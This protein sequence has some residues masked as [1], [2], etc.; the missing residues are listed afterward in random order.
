MCRPLA[1]V[2][3][4]R[5]AKNKRRRNAVSRK[6]VKP[7]Q[8][9][10]ERSS[11]PSVAPL[12]F[13]F[14]TAATRI[15]ASEP[16]FAVGEPLPKRRRVMSSVSVAIADD[17]VMV[18][19]EAPVQ[20]PSAEILT[21]PD[22]SDEKMS[23]LDVLLPSEKSGSSGETMHE[24]SDL[25][26]SSENAG[27][28][29]L[30][31]NSLD[32]TDDILHG[33]FNSHKSS[34]LNSL[35]LTDDVF[36]GLFRSKEALAAKKAIASS[37]ERTDNI[38]HGLFSAENVASAK[39]NT[40]S[41]LERTEDLFHGLFASREAVSEEGSL[42]KTDD[43]L[44]GLFQSK[45]AAEQSVKSEEEETKSVETLAKAEHGTKTSVE[46]PEKMECVEQRFFEYQESCNSITT[47]VQETDALIELLVQSLKEKSERIVFLERALRALISQQ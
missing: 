44:H 25:F 20:L 7:V 31:V 32:L 11:C 43:V 18:E 41:S 13:G 16:R 3:A 30:K 36:H 47:Y 23:K 24:L 27:T 1:V 26:G 15:V 8:V 5:A 14:A 37:L 6:V 21:Q 9:T 39:K 28:A 4:R 19:P 45:E 2:A 40:A 17:T 22:K 34:R 46:V 38:F 42:E 12:S 10:V 35:E 29:P 33:L